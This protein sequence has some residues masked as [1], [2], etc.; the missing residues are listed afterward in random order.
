[1]S[2]VGIKFAEGGRVFGI[3]TDLELNNLDT[4]VVETVRGIELGIVS[5]LGKK[6]EPQEEVKNIIRVATEQDLKTAKEQQKQ[7]PRI[8]K[9]T[10][11]L[12]DKYKLE[13]K[14]VNVSLTLDGTKV[15]I[16][17]VCEDRVDFRDLV[18]DLAS[19]LKLRIELRQI[20]IRDQAKIVGGIGFC[21]K[22]CCCK[23]YLN[24]FDK[25]SIKMAKA[26]GLSLNPTKISGI[27]GRL[28]CCLAYENEF[29]ADISAKMPKLNSR[30]KTKDGIGI[31]VYN[32]L[33]KQKVTV[34]IDAGNEIKVSEYDLTEIEVLPKIQPEQ[35]KKEQKQEKFEQVEKTEEKN[36]ENNNNKN[37]FNKKKKKHNNN[38]KRP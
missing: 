5:P 17:Y 36:K 16:N 19:Q 26:Q 18:K 23:K 6:D 31:A 25:V 15:I 38:G 10:N 22:E 3:E 7:F 30:V 29:Y 8:T 2:K 32:N 1:M 24:D 34:K 12:I 37:N 14:L 20:G 11:E 28:M 4:V 35:P 21:G 33:L 27:C 13:M 9:I